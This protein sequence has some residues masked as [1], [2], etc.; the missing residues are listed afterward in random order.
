MII[1]MR[2]IRLAP[3]FYIKELD[4]TDLIYKINEFSLLIY[5]L[6]LLG[7]AHM[8]IPIMSIKVF[9]YLTCV[10]ATILDITRTNHL[11]V[12]FYAPHGVSAFFKG[13]VRNVN[14]S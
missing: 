7:Q 14:I 3:R 5:I 1:M 4:L 11:I 13:D 12:D 9:N 10:L 8:I 6:G 2:L